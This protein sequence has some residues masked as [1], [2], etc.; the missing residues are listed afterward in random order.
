MTALSTR[1]EPGGQKR[2][3]CGLEREKVLRGAG[4]NSNISRLPSAR[5]AAALTPGSDLGKFLP[6]HVSLSEE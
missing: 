4:K 3:G 5:L 6:E 2:G 1:G